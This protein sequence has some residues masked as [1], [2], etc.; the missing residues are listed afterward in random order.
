MKFQELEIKKLIRHILEEE[1]KNGRMEEWKNGRMD[2][3]MEVV[4]VKK[5]FTAL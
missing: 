2:Y 3:W 1:W 5:Y 4:K